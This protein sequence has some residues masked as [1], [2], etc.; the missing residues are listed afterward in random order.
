MRDKTVHRKDLLEAKSTQMPNG[1]S[2]FVT[3]NFS[4]GR[5]L[6]LRGTPVENKDMPM[7]EFGACGIQFDRH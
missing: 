7:K 2:M 5:K 6:S 3:E 1:L 4:E